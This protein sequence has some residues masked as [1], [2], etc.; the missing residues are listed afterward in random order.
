MFFSKW[1]L[2]TVIYNGRE[3]VKKTPT[4]TNPSFVC[5]SLTNKT[6]TLFQHHFS[7]PEEQNG[8]TIMSGFVFTPRIFVKDH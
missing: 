8:E 4:Q 6:K 3:S 5:P 7:P 2:K 1:S